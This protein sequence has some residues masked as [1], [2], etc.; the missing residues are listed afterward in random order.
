MELFGRTERLLLRRM[1]AAD[2]DE[3]ALIMRGRQVRD[4]WEH[5]FTDADVRDWIDKNISYYEKYQLGYFL[6]LKKDTDTVVG[7]IALMPD[8]IDGKTYYE[9]GYILKEEF[10][11]QGFATEGAQFM[12]AL[13]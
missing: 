7:Q 3:V 10:T 8:E 9:V 13:D 4:I 5:A 12:M 6:A 1:T 2:F 11:G